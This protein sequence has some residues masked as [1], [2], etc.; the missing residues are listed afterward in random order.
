ML[1][2]GIDIRPLGGPV[3]TGIGEYAYELLAALFRTAPNHEYILF[4]S[5][6][7]ARTA[8]PSL[9]AGAL[10][11]RLRVPNK[12]FHAAAL[13][14]GQPRADRF[15]GGVDVFF[16]LNLGITALSRHTPHV[17]TIHDLSFEFFPDCFSLKQRLWHRAAQ[18]RKQAREAAAII[19]PS[20][21]TKRDVVSF[22]GVDEKKVHVV[23]H[24]LPS[25]FENQESGIKNREY[26]RKKYQLPEK[27]I[28]YVGAIEPRK[29]VSGLVEAFIYWKKRHADRAKDY[30]LVLAGPM[31]F[32]ADAL[33]RGARGL[34]DIRYLGYVSAEDKPGLYAGASLFLYPSFYEGF[35]F[36]VLEAMAMSVPVVAS[37]R[38]SLPE[39]ANGAAYLVNPY[40]I[41]DI[42]EGMHRLT[43][44]DALRA[45]HRGEGLRRA[46]HFNWTKAAEQTLALFT[47]LKVS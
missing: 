22:Y 45:W 39:V 17:L 5:G 10:V 9:P 12:I 42:A 33:L 46:T 25:Q 15:L 11:K 35:G 37:N 6:L 32:R 1:R 29:N 34:E 31:G 30:A 14:C 40:R 28:L 21:N 38:S 36:P 26:V 24:G 19:V 20:E 47:H 4:E 27:Y 3:R 23:P 8:L 7:S 44:G 43:S 18:P 2:I 13:T 41:S 16:S